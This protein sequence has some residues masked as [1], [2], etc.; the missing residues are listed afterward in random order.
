MPFKQR[1]IVKVKKGLPDENG[2]IKTHPFL[3]ISCETVNASEP[4]RVYIG[5][6]M[7][8]NQRTDK[9]TFKIEPDMLEGQ[10]KEEWCQIRLYIIATF[11]ESQISRDM[12]H[13]LGTIKPIPFNVILER[14]KNY[15]LIKDS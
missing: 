15:V 13:F 14:I 2:E 8:H 3:I 9:F 4:E 5:V 7:T 11:K 1:Q 12:T 10:W 6:M